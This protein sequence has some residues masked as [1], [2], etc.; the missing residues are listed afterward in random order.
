MLASYIRVV[1]AW[2][3]PPTLGIREEYGVLLGRHTEGIRHC[4]DNTVA[5]W[6]EQTAPL[7]DGTKPNVENHATLRCLGDY[8]LYADCL[9]QRL[10]TRTWLILSCLPCPDCLPKI[11]AGKRMQNVLTSEVKK[12]LHL[13][14]KSGY[15]YCTKHRGHDTAT[16]ENHSNT[17]SPTHC[18]KYLLRL[19]RQT[20]RENDTP[21]P[22]TNVW[23][24]KTNQ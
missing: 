2:K 17:S 5:G 12:P 3:C 18:G 14:Q 16:A 22:P 8:L 21:L 10:V 13:Y 1:K 20:K 4:L 19:V 6:T 7:K 24:W 11:D 23:E 9:W 15:H